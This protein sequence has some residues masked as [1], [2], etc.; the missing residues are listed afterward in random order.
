M[1]HTV[2]RAAILAE[3]NQESLE[4]KALVQAARAQEATSL[5]R[6][7]NKLTFFLDWAQMM[8]HHKCGPLGC[9]ALVVKISK[10]LVN[11]KT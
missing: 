10:K 6:T 7:C 3:L 9:T 4:L 1:H 5:T 11:T 2:V 8:T